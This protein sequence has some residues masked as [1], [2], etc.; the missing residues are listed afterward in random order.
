MSFFKIGRGC[1]QGDPLSP[2]LFIICVEFLAVK[3]RNNKNI[4]GIK[5]NNIE[6]RISQYADDTSIILYGSESSLNQTI[7][8]LER[9]SRISGLHVN[10][11]KT[12][13]VWIG[14]EKYSTNSI[15]TKWKLSWGKSSFKVLGIIFNID[16]EKMI[17]VNYASKIQQVEKRI[18][19]WE[20]SLSPIGKITVIKT[21]LLP[22]FKNLL[23]SL[24]N[25]N[26]AVLNSINEIF[27]NFLWNKKAKIKKIS[28][29][30]T[31]LR[32]GVEND[33]YR[34][35]QL[36]FKSDMDQKTYYRQLQMARLHSQIC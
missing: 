15:K 4:K 29:G 32:R 7:S 10:F 25:P 18:K 6:F 31:V 21:L 17:K 3:I 2:Y 20:R 36:C 13:L 11:E 9:F 16:L 23:L 5:V 1:R 14:S 30:K 19:Q 35:F 8:E 26:N 34:S 12:Q 22:I 24:P 27:Y 33:K 28:G